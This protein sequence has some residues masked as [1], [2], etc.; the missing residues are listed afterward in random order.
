MD[1]NEKTV[2]DQSDGMAALKNFII[3]QKEADYVAYLV[4]L[5]KMDNRFLALISEDAYAVLRGARTDVA[6]LSLKLDGYT[7]TAK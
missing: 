3:L 2:R 4:F 7:T 5:L 1:S 6:L